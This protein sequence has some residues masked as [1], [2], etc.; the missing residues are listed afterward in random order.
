MSLSLSLL[1]DDEAHAFHHGDASST[2][3]SA[4]LRPK[5][6]ERNELNELSELNDV[7]WQPLGGCY[8][9]FDLAHA[10]MPHTPAS[11]HIESISIRNSI[12]VP[13]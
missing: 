11:T 9:V 2:S 8:C 4:S 12:L 7:E 13:P 10:L 3:P 1:A 5:L 6:N